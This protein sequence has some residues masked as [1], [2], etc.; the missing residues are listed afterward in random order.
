MSSTR[1]IIETITRINDN[2]LQNSRLTEFFDSVNTNNEEEEVG[3]LDDTIS[4]DTREVN[5]TTVVKDVKENIVHCCF[6]TKDGRQMEGNISSYFADKD[7]LPIFEFTARN[8]YEIDKPCGTVIKATYIDKLPTVQ[9]MTVGIW[10]KI[11]KM[12]IST[13]FHI[14]TGLSDSTTIN[15]NQAV[16]M[17]PVDIKDK[18]LDDL[19]TRKPFIKY[20]LLYTHIK[21]INTAYPNS[22][23]ILMTKMNRSEIIKLAKE[24]LQKPV[25]LCFYKTKT[26]KHL[27]ELN[28]LKFISIMNRLDEMAV[29]NESYRELQIAA[30]LRIA[31]Y[32]YNIIKMECI[33]AFNDYIKKLKQS[34]NTYDEKLVRPIEKWPEPEQTGHMYVR[35]DYIYSTILNIYSC[36]YKDYTT[37]FIKRAL[38]WLI[39]NKILI[40]SQTVIAKKK[41]NILY[42]EHIYNE[43]ENI[44]SIV[45][46]LM[47][48]REATV[49]TLASNFSATNI[50]STIDDRTKI[51][52][53]SKIVHE[54]R[55]ISIECPLMIDSRCKELAEQY[56]FNEDKNIGLCETDMETHR[57][58]HN[59]MTLYNYTEDLKNDPTKIFPTHHCPISHKS[60]CRVTLE[61]AEMIYLALNNQ[62]LNAEQR[63]AL[64]KISHYAISTISGMGGTGKT[65]LMGYVKA[66]FS[67]RPSYCN[68]YEE[69]VAAT[70]AGRASEILLEKGIPSATFASYLA[71]HDSYIINIHKRLDDY[72]WTE[73]QK[74]NMTNSEKI[75]F[76]ESKTE[77][78]MK[79]VRV[80][81]MD[82]ASMIN[83]SYI[84]K[85]LRLL[86]GY[87]QLVKVI[88]V[89]D[90]FQLPPISGGRPFED[91][92]EGI[93]IS[94]TELRRNMRNKTR[95]HFD[96]SQKIRMRQ[97]DLEYDEEMFTFTHCGRTDPGQAV[98]EYITSHDIINGD[99]GWTDFHC[100]S[101]RRED[102]EIKINHSCYE[103]FCSMHP[104]RDLFIKEK[105]KEGVLE[106]P[107]KIF[108]CGVKLYATKNRQK[109]YGIQNGLIF[110]INAYIDA[111]PPSPVDKKNAWLNKWYD[112]STLPVGWTRSHNQEIIYASH[113]P[114]SHPTV[115]FAVCEKMSN[116][117]TFLLPVS[118]KYGLSLS[119]SMFQL[120]YGNTI[121]K[122]QGSQI[123]HA[124][125]YIRYMT[126]VTNFR[127]FYTA[128]GRS[129]ETTHL[130]APSINDIIQCIQTDYPERRSDMGRL[131]RERLLKSCSI[132]SIKKAIDIGNKL[133]NEGGVKTYIDKTIDNVDTKINELLSSNNGED[134]LI[135]ELSNHSVENPTFY[136]TMFH[137][138][139]NSMIRSTDSLNVSSSLSNSV[140][141]QSS[142]NSMDSFRS[143]TPLMID[144]ENGEVSVEDMLHSIKTQNNN[145][146]IQQDPKKWNIG[147]D[148]DS[149]IQDSVSI[150]NRSSNRT[151]KDSDSLIMSLHSNR[152]R[153]NKYKLHYGRK[154]TGSNNNQIIKLKDDTSFKQ[155]IVQE[156]FTMLEEQK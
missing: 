35:E 45:E 8:L 70:I 16:T 14:E 119:S 27:P 139:S 41:Q 89:G 131:I 102:A 23:G 105:N 95:I 19:M 93:S 108:P 65:T 37:E 22:I 20:Y 134:L 100:L 138:R 96:N 129:E 46:S 82:E 145:N 57:K 117:K 55:D 84:E 17:L 140:G 9:P 124:L 34:R 59:A 13:D 98:S 60:H 94:S 54:Q 67:R 63:M 120:G 51:K 123:P 141:L 111:E 74:K 72:S 77:H 40:K 151:V 47:V 115:R 118:G 112:K 125:I 142:E 75:A 3:P 58:I 153:D 79:Q 152:Y 110:T 33:P 137:I 126:G 109:D 62:D 106:Y 15:Y 66:V 10:K 127:L 12:F 53:S 150:L 24:I 64:L 85:L 86:T 143:K 122:F 30:Y 121:C 26:N 87:G 90:L 61:E 18:L 6:T 71:S 39:T 31:V 154:F 149:Y 97:T 103:L 32:I 128:V 5:L 83:I 29:L 28:I 133:V 68:L 99:I 1:F 148:N 2:N 155:D 114:P 78:R 52:Q 130:F 4:F 38:D 81:L 7:M 147:F 48:K 49:N 92:A 43:Q 135:S 25:A 69:C 80:L 42:L 104:D 146:K 136:D 11:C 56:I 21:E 101:T 156:L 144:I 76:L 116:H 73:D 91:I 113:R 36:D 50:Y 44:V 107:K 88:L 132:V